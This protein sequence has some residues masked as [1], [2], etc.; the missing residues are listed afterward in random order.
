M[1]AE[2]TSMW[3]QY[4]QQ[5][6]PD[7]DPA[8][9]VSNAN[10]LLLPDDVPQ[11][12]KQ[13]VDEYNQQLKVTIGKYETVRTSEKH[14]GPKTVSIKS[15]QWDYVMSY[16]ANNVIDFNKLE[17]KVCVLNGPNA[18]GKSTLLDVICIGLFGTPTHMRSM[19]HGQKKS[20][21]YLISGD[22]RPQDVP[23]RVCMRLSVDGDLYDVIRTYTGSFTNKDK[24]ATVK[25]VD[26]SKLSITSDE[27]ENTRD[28]LSIEGITN[29]DDWVHT[30]LNV[31]SIDDILLS[32]MMC[33]VDTDNFLFAKQEDQKSIL[34]RVLNMD[35]VYA[36]GK[37]IKE[38]H[39]AHVAVI[40]LIKNSLATMDGLIPDMGLSEGAGAGAG[41]MARKEVE[42]LKKALLEAQSRVDELNV[43]LSLIHISEPRDLSTSRMP[44]SA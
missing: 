1:A 3:V 35:S 21:M 8:K 14:R 38:S 2:D 30:A 12:I 24:T 31:S 17:S 19:Q 7:V 26:N 32:N 33:Q 11:S 34:D 6:A 37:A 4:L 43:K 40:Q 18:S 27:T 41:A 25:T 44:S 23:M 42:Q 22:K 20:N 10:S 16:G 29:V 28:G 9:W 39:A 13:Q 36:F 5:V 15:L